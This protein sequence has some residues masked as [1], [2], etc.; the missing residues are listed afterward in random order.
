MVKRYRNSLSQ[1]FGINLTSKDTPIKFLQRML[2][3]IGYSLKRG[4]TSQGYF[5]IPTPKLD[6]DKIQAIFTYWKE[7]IEKKKQKKQDDQ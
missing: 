5:Y 6:E 4:E 7:L 1:F 2:D 3:K